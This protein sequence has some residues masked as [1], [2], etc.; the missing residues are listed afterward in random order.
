MSLYLYTYKLYIIMYMALPAKADNIRRPH[1]VLCTT[2][3]LKGKINPDYV[4]D[5]NFVCVRYNIFLM[6]Q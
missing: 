6:V 2:N 1:Y 4:Y 5:E 3:Q